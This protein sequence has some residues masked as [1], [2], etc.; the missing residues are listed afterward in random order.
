MIVW[1]SFNLLNG[2]GIWWLHAGPK[3]GILTKQSVRWY[4]INGILLRTR[5]TQTFIHFRRFPRY[6]IS[7]RSG[8]GFVMLNEN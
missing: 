2:R 5:N 8:K 7:K 4:N 1:Y 3:G 6:M